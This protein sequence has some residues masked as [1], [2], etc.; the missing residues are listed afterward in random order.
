VLVSNL[1][2]IADPDS[3][4]LATL[5]LLLSVS[6]LLALFVVITW[7]RDDDWLAAGFL[8]G[9]TIMLAGAAADVVVGIIQTGSLGGAIVTS[10]GML[11]ALV[12]RSL[13][14]VPIAGGVIALAR[15]I[16][17]KVQAGYAHQPGT[18]LAESAAAETTQSGSGDGRS[19]A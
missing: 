7:F 17:R 18:P 4:L 14:A 15:F 3:L 8:F 10:V 19:T 9:I 13:I 16:T 1:L 12:F 6:A 5:S 11:M 2:V